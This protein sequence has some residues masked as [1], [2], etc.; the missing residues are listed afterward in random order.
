MLIYVS[1]QDGEA[2]VQVMPLLSACIILN[3]SLPYFEFLLY[4]GLSIC[5]FVIYQLKYN[6]STSL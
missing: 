2:R 4:S 3:N 6:Y 1:S 5:M